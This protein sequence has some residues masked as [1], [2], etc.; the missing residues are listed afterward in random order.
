M[1][2]NLSKEA[3]PHSFHTE[4]ISE[5][6]IGLFLNPAYLQ[7]APLPEEPFG[8]GNAT[9]YQWLLVSWDSHPSEERP[10][11]PPATR[12]QKYHC[13]H[14]FHYGEQPHHTAV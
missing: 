11:P 1:W 8:S 3:L 10:K 13:T 5:F 2:Q 4:T 6:L 14:L 12:G 7:H 9:T